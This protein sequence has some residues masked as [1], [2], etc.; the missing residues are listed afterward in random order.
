MTTLNRHPMTPAVPPQFIE[1]IYTPDEIGLLVDI[2]RNNGPWRLVAAHHFKNAEEYMAVSGAKNRDTE[3]PLQLS[4][5]LTPTFRSYFGDGGIVYE[6]AAHDLYY[7]RKFMDMIKGIHGAQYAIPSSYLFNIRTPAHSFDGGHFD[8]ATWRGVSM[9][10]APLWLVSVM[11]KSGLFERWEVKTGQVIAYF[12]D[13]DID[14]GFTYWPNGPELPPQR[15][16]APFWNSGLLTNNEKMFHRGEANGPRDRR[17]IPKLQLNSV[18]TGDGDDGW[19]VRNGDEDIARFANADMR[20]LFHYSAYVFDDRAAVKAYLDHTD[21]L[22]VDQAIGMLIDDV[23]ARG[24]TVEEPTDPLND[25]GL[26]ATLTSVYAMAPSE[27]PDVAPLD[28]P[29]PSL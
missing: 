2:V 25:A 8:G 15:F 1:N 26:M 22:T 10:N 16:A 9:N 7:N 23:R 6:P 21:D 11:A 29:R 3:V 27:Y 13:S 24:I 18:I 5:L 14:G 17:T 28:V 12:Y 20:M 4:D 19:V